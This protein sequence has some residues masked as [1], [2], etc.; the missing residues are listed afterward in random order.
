M[1]YNTVK[2]FLLLTCIAMYATINTQTPDDSED[3]IT[4]AADF[5]TGL[6]FGPGR[7][8]PPTQNNQPPPVA[9][10]PPDS[11]QGCK[12]QNVFLLQTDFINNIT[13]TEPSYGDA[14]I[15]YNIYRDPALT[16]LVAT[17]PA[18]ATSPLQY[19]DH[20][21]QPNITYSYYIVSVDAYG[22]MSA[23]NSV[24][25]TQACS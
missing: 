13:W 19:Y 23:V 21:R 17:V 5:K 25:V 1:K 7:D 15:A 18:T 8:T 11:V 12:T 4:N 2:A 16:E 10:Y 22:N 9:I 6:P 14:P 24:T 20:N 3:S